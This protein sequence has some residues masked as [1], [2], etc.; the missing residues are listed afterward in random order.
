MHQFSTQVLDRLDGMHQ[1][2][3][4]RLRGLVQIESVNPTFPGVAYE[5]AVG[6]EGAAASY[7]CAIYKEY[8]SSV[9]LIG[10]EPGRENGVAVIEGS[11]GGPSLLFNGHLDVVPA[12]RLDG[13]TNGEPYEGRVSGGRMW[14]RGTADQKGGLISQALAVAAIAR[15]RVRLRGDLLLQA[16][17]GEEM[18]EHAIGV[19]EVLRHGYR[20]DA[21]IVSEPT[22][23]TGRLVVCAASPGVLVF[24]LVVRGSMSHPCNRGDDERSAGSANEVGVN[25]IEK[26]LVVVAGLGRLE[27][28]WRE[29]K[30]HPLFP[31]GQFAFH[32]ASLKSGPADAHPA[33]SEAERCAARYSCWYPP[34]ADA[35]AVRGE[36]A[37]RLRTIAKLDPWLQS[38]PPEL[39]W[40]RHWPPAS[41]PLPHPLVDATLEAHRRARGMPTRHCDHEVAGFP[42]VCDASFLQRSG[43]P[44]AIFGPGSLRQAHGM[45]EYVEINEVIEAAKTYAALAMLW[46]GARRA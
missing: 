35:D 41:V 42:A 22:G 3:V 45:N 2:I 34:D 8:A 27:T 30:T 16:V 25:A 20:A 24:E 23:S 21:A 5:D 31:R 7:L 38:H 17:A 36:I 11:G 6:G 9:A 13:W 4:E 46:C 19:T 14:G 12:G 28:D 44:T 32:L 10:A 26:M 15:E 1:E 33:P 40:A 37:D 43:I 18:M 29:S 39:R